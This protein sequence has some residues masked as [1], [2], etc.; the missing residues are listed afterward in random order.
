MIS[1]TPLITIHHY[2]DEAEHI[3]DNA[4]SISRSTAKGEKISY[5]RSGETAIDA[6]IFE[7]PKRNTNKS[8]SSR[9][10]EIVRNNTIA[11][12][13]YW[14]EWQGLTEIIDKTL[15]EP[16]I[17]DEE[18]NN[19]LQRY[20][21]DS[22]KFLFSEKW[23][24]ASIS[25]IRNMISAYR[26]AYADDIDATKQKLKG[27]RAQIAR[28]ASRI[29]PTKDLVFVGYSHKDSAH[30]NSIRKI[31]ESSPRLP[32]ERY[33]DDTTIGEGQEWNIEIKRAIDDASLAILLLSESFN[34]SEYIQTKEL[35]Y[36]MKRFNNGA[37]DIIPVLVDGT[38]ADYSPLDKLQFANAAQP[39][40]TITPDE[41]THIANRILKRITIHPSHSL[42]HHC[43]CD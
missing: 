3:H 20:I 1:G 27:L 32:R 9:R 24:G 13:R 29:H 8:K 22:T 43:I 15:S 34:N 33:F 21:N 31:I 6:W 16:G 23:H 4:T 38:P 19:L 18:N 14:S 36:L 35:P 40:S 42:E 39:L 41:I 7:L 2:P 17:F 28:K 11:I 25:E 5:Q 12:M 37:L 26:E 30:L 10:I